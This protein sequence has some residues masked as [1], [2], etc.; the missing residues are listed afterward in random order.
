M[1]NTMKFFFLDWS[2]RTACSLRRTISNMRHGTIHKY[3]TDQMANM[4]SEADEMSCTVNTRDVVQVAKDAASHLPPGGQYI[5]S[6]MHKAHAS[7]DHLRDVAHRTN[8]C[9][10]I[11]MTNAQDDLHS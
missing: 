1:A 8:T 7:Q 6:P 2:L 5:P 4:Q 11:C 10:T 3:K 9:T